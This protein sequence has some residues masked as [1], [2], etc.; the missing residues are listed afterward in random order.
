MLFDTRDGRLRRTLPVSTGGG[1][2]YRG[3]GGRLHVA[4]TPQGRFQV[5]RKVRSWDESYLGRLYYPVYFSGG[6]AIHGSTSVPIRPVSHGCVRI[7]LWLAKRFHA[8][9]PVGTGVIV[10]S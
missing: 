7:P 6:Y 3:L 9:H 10:T 8:E 2:T 5:F 1:Y 4:R